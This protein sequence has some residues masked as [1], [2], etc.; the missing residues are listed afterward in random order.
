MDDFEKFKQ[1]LPTNYKFFNALTNR[2]I[3]DKNYEYV[4]NIWK[5]F[6]KNTMKDDQDLYL[7]V[8]VLLLACVFETFEEEFFWI[9]S[10]SL[11][12]YSEL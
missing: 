6:N 11:F 4:V 1:V 8:Y 7:K 10:C 5:S 9:S 2:A 12:I 3:S